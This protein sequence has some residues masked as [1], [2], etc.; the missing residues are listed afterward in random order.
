[1]C[2]LQGKVWLIDVNPFGEVTDSLLFTWEEL[3][4]GGELTQQQVSHHDTLVLKNEICSGTARKVFV[5]DL[6]SSDAEFR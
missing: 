1:M 5:F 6:Y 3:T 4:S 2:V